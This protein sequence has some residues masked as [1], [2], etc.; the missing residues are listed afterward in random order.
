MQIINQINKAKAEPRFPETTL[1]PILLMHVQLQKNLIKWLL[2]AASIIFTGACGSSEPYTLGPIKTFDPDN[3]DIP[4]PSESE[5][6]FGWESLY[7]STFYQI[8]K[9]LDLGWTFRK[10]GGLVGLAKPEEAKNVNVLD[11]VP[12]SSWYTRR[13]Y[14]ETM[15]KRALKQ[16]PNKSGGVD[17]G[18]PITVIRGKSEGVTPGFTIQDAGGN[19]YIVKIDVAQFPEMASSS[20]V[21][22]TLIYYASG[23]YTPQNSLVFLEPKQLIVGE[24]ATLTKQEVKK[25]M[26]QADLDTLLSMAYK[27]EDGKIRALA[28]KYVEGRPLGPWSFEG[29]RKDDPNDLVP[30][31]DR[32]EVRGLGVLA[33]WLN[34]TD[35]R[36]GNTLASYVNENGNGYIRHYLLDMGSTIGIG[37]TDLRHIKQGNE[38]RFDPRYMALLYTSLGLY[39]KPWATEQA[40]ERP[41]YPSVGYFES[42]IFDPARWVAS[43]PNPAFDKITPRDGFWG[44]K[45]VMAFSDEDIRTIVGA[46]QLTN[47]EAEKYLIQ[48]LKERRDKIGRYWFSKVNPLDKFKAQRNGDKLTLSFADLG[49]DGNL[50]DITESSYIWSAGAD[51]HI[52]ADQRISNSPVLELDLE[53]LNLSNQNEEVILKFEINTL[54]NGELVTKKNTAVYV[55]LT[56]KQGK[57]VGLRRY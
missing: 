14:F 48:T 41:F 7:Y 27:G 6:N 8:E 5:E 19:V 24:E 2:I 20:E 28:S 46:G 1:V 50:F 49:V 15:D 10:A 3:R 26:T 13:H 25:P 12:N 43:Y 30:H 47:P 17:T 37:G 55:A 56:N 4:M 23:Y 34:D 11:E 31:E 39:V 16:G 32:R 22:S 29:T 44:A 52:L 35:R 53:S 33:S 9:P 36:K 18:K 21:I 54:R 45:M 38:Y 40:K 51:K 42:Q 57:V